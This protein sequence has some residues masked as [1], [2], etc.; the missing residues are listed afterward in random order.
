M[1]VNNARTHDIIQN[2]LDNNWSGTV[3]QR[4]IAAFYEV[5]GQRVAQC[6]NLDLTAADHYLI[7]RYVI[8]TCSPAV[9]T[10][11]S[12]MIGV[13]DGLYKGANEL[14]KAAGGKDIVYRT[15]N[16]PAASFSP[17]VAAWA[18]TGVTDGTVDCG[19]RIWRSSPK[20]IAPDVPV[21]WF[22]KS[23]WT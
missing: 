11:Y 5:N 12:A 16:C 3:K 22:S 6:E 10:V 19:W 8:V 4:L 18:M 17:L 14:I 23:A 2:A 21:G 15:G 20:L 1:G 9:A 7:S 13:Y